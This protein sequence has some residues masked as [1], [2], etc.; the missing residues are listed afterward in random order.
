MRL[1]RFAFLLL[2]GLWSAATLQAQAVRWEPSDADP[3]DLTLVFENCSPDGAPQ[4]PAVEGVQFRLTGQGSHTEFNNFR[5]TSYIRLTYRFQARAN[6]P[7]TIPAFNLKTDRGVLTVPAFTAS[8]SR[9]STLESAAASQLTPGSPTVWA[10][11]VFPL[12]YT[13]QVTRRNFSQLGS[14]PDWRAV[15]LVAEDW[16]KPELTEFINSGE[17]RLNIS[18]RSRAYA[19]TAGLLTLNSVA[20][21]V[22]LQTG[23]I[24]F[25][26]FQA[27]RVEQVGVESNKPK[28]TVRELPTPPAAFSGAV[29]QFKL[30]SRIVPEN[31][32]V[33]EPI[34]WTLE[35]SGSGN[36][37]DIPGL[38]SRQVSN[39]FQVIQP[40]A[41]RT[42]SDGKL[43]DVVLAEDVVLVPT[44]AGSYAL[45]PVDFI[46]FD[47]KAEEYKTISTP[48]T[49]LTI[50]APSA[51]QFNL[52]PSGT[53]NP[54]PDA[55]AGTNSGA[56]PAQRPAPTVPTLPAGIPRDPLP[57][58]TDVIVPLTKP[59]LIGCLLASVAAVLAFWGWLALKHARQTDPVR[60]RREAR[61]RLA[62][63]IA[64]LAGANQATRRTLLLQW[65]HDAARLWQLAHAAP[66]A[67]ALDD[68]AW[69]RLWAEAD[70]ALYGVGSELPTDWLVRAQA[71]LTEKRIA[72]FRPFRLFLPHN[73]FPAVALLVLATLLL[74]AL[75]AAVTAKIDPAAA[76]QRGDFAA[77]EKSWRTRIAATPTDWRA[78]HNLSL[79]LA[80][81]DRTGEA[82]AQS[83]AAFVQHPSHA[84]VRWHLGLVC[85][86]AGF[87]PPA[88]ALFFQAGP[89]A[90]LA[91]LASPAGW[92]V[93]FIAAIGA[94]CLA[95]GWLMA[96]AYGRRNRTVFRSSLIALTFSGALG[97][98]ALVGWSSYGLANQTNAVVVW[99]AAT[100]R[101]IPTEADTTQKT[102]PVAAGAMATSESK[103]LG[104]TRVS[105][106]NGQT[107]WLRK[108]DFVELWR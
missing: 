89:R 105:F 108:D 79:A 53:G 83:V 82:A 106:S 1:V 42:P 85:E 81:Q 77:A 23:S 52:T 26:I 70:R 9:S 94:S 51:S 92:Q 37:P 58:T 36:W 73:L 24:G 35:L 3:A 69:S 28:I 86:K 7:F 101:S 59:T 12:T 46:Y 20:Q 104:W 4:L 47:P 14:N 98:L 16:S 48:R 84:A 74:P 19:K 8:A 34:T 78:R 99:R 76:Y 5:R 100:L 66:A 107:G 56:P 93:T 102:T 95:V 60:P 54:T 45:G 30:V 22:N 32:A 49:A 68:S 72:P 75:P 57:G 38:P 71:A 65:Q 39:D 44:K 40:K 55:S 96:N 29:G 62:E 67:R 25:S 63:T 27:P 10:G 31:A 97:A 18:Y 64:K 103:F 6:T 33:G 2:A 50:T 61:A 88:I 87:V 21:L 13:L 41:K 11:E 17:A 15:P 91:Q 80:Q 43:F 90:S